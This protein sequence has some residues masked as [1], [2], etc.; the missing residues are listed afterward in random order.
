MTWWVGVPFGKLGSLCV[1][2]NTETDGSY[3]SRWGGIKETDGN[4]LPDAGIS[5]SPHLHSRE[6]ETFLHLHL[7]L[8]PDFPTNA[9]Q[10]LMQMKSHSRWRC[11]GKAVTGWQPIDGPDRELDR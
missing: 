6:K 10:E 5:R 3:P 9:S 2:G 7:E 11:N 1:D 4:K 8:E